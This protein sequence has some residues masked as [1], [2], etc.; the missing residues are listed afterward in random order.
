VRAVK[1]MFRGKGG[2]KADP[3]AKHLVK[4]NSHPENSS[5]GGSSNAG[6]SVI[7]GN[8]E[9]EGKGN[10]WKNLGGRKSRRMQKTPSLPA[11]KKKE[12]KWGIHIGKW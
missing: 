5:G 1:K 12:R 8:L 11:E 10:Q 9:G 6:D 7:R 3:T 2:K 4:Y